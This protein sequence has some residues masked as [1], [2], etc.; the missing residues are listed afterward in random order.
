[1]VFFTHAYPTSYW[2]HF[3]LWTAVSFLLLLDWL[4]CIQCRQ[5]VSPT[6]DRS[7]SVK[8]G[9]IP[10]DVMMHRN[11]IMRVKEWKGRH[12]DHSCSESDYHVSVLSVYLSGYLPPKGLSCFDILRKNV[13]ALWLGQYLDIVSSAYLT[14]MGFMRFM[15]YILYRYVQYLKGM[16][17]VWRTKP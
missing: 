2:L 13:V 17:T 16:L 5:R 14:E 6:G 15:I 8:T 12:S 10:R 11:T 9:A 4:L 7:Y 1:M 3:H